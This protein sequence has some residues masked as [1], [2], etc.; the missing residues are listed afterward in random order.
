WRY[1]TVPG[2]AAVPPQ[3]WPANSHIELNPSGATLVLFA[4]PRCPC[5]R[6]TL[7]ELQRI[8]AESPKNVTPWI[9][10]YRPLDREADWEHAD[11]WN[12]AS[13]IPGAHLI[14]DPGGNLAREF[15]VFTSGQTLLYS[16]TGDLEFSGGITS[17][18]GHEGDN[19]G[20]AA[21]V[22]WLRGGVR[23]IHETPVFG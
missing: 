8:L 23:A 1:A 19:A 4:H 9:V 15:H 10:F 3:H 21:I 17:E 11:L 12:I 13:T 7:A 16:G 22:E 20:Q 6:A 14:P 5:T 18:R 2:N